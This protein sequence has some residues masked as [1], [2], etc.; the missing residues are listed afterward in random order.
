MSLLAAARSE[1][2]KQF[3]TAGWWVLAI[4]LVAYVAFTAGVLALVFGGVASGRLPGA[5]GPTPS[6]DGI[7]A[8]VYSSAS[9]VGYVFPLL[10]GT[11]M[12]TTEFRHKTL[13]PTFLATP[14][15]G[16]ILVGKFVVGIVVGL[17][18]GILGSAAAI[19]AGAGVLSFF[20]VDTALGSA[21]TWELVGRML[22]AFA[23]WA[24]VGIGVGTVVR[25]QVA[26]IVI[27]LAVTLFIE[28]IVRTIGG[29]IDGF[30]DV[31]KWFPSA[32]SDALVGQ[33]IF[34]AMGTG[35]GGTLEWWAGGLVLLGYAVVLVVIGLLTTWRRDID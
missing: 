21:D 4:V 13:T 26:A 15:R 14:R 19:G 10:V 24:L 7:P 33:T 23:L 11:L 2:T 27:V 29:V 6:A 17:L 3:T 25:N 5:S 16:V 18:Y 22:L 34:G 35:S 31:V 12:V 9:A 28:P 1:Y 8:L 30:A 20:G 32:A